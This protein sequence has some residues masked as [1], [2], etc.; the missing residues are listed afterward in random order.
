MKAWILDKQDN[1]MNRPLRLV[2]NYLDP[3]PKNKQIRIKMKY[4]GI[5]RTD[6]H[7]AEGDIPLHKKP[8]ILGHEIVGTVDKLGEDSERFKIGDRV[9]VTWLYKSCGSCEY[10]INGFENYC[11]HIVRT[12]WDVDGGY[13]EYTLAYEDYVLPLN[14]IPLDYEDLAPLM[15]PGVASYLCYKLADPKPGDRIGIIGFGPT[16]YYLLKTANFLGVDVYVSTR[17]KHHREIA[18]EYGAKW[19]GNIV[20]EDFPIKLDH[21]ISFPPVG[22]IVEKALENL[23]PSGNLVL[24]QVAS[25]PI[26]INNYGNLWGRNIKTVYNVR[27]ST[28]LEML[29]LARKIDYRIEKRIFDF[30]ELQDAMIMNRQGKVKELT[31]VLKIE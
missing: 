8:V 24:A 2:D 12:G 26:T 5:C 3:E 18:V 29:K 11:P 16:A 22:N 27:R 19:V 23:K 30:E 4:C 25:T 13:A 28:S 21:I 6:I 31:S 20:E 9:G 14:N 1:I 10:C 17:S 7:I 15:C